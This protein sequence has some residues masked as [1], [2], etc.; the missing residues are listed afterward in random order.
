MKMKIAIV[1]SFWTCFVPRMY[2]TGFVS[3]NELL[4]Q[5]QATLNR[6]AN[7]QVSRDE[8]DDS[9]LCVAYIDGAMDTQGQTLELH[10]DLKTFRY[11]LPDNVPLIQSV[12]VIV[13]FLKEHPEKL[14]M[15]A[16]LLISVALVDVFPCK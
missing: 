7:P 12:R 1:M 2:A 3:G 6:E 4:K 13:K 15:R 10:P 9:L 14:H 11:C 16:S 8:Q 5:C